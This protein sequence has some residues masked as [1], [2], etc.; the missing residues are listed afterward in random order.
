MSRASNSKIIPVSTSK[1]KLSNPSAISPRSSL[2]Q[3]KNVSSTNK[4]PMNNTT[5]GFNK[6]NKS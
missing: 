2:S 1:I 6:T 4:F 3:N 5:T